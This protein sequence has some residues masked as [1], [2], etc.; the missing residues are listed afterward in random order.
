[1]GAGE[2]SRG[3][4]GGLECILA[5]RE[6]KRVQACGLVAQDC[7]WG[8]GPCGSRV[9]C[10]AQQGLTLPCRRGRVGKGRL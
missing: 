2:L 7:C 1:M 3:P 4:P 5:L 6:E 8:V 10:R 9:A